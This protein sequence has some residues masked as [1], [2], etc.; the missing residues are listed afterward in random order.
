MLSDGLVRKSQVLEEFSGSVE[1]SLL[2]RVGLRSL[3]RQTVRRRR[4]FEHLLESSDGF[5]LQNKCLEILASAQL[6][7][8]FL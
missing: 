7:L 2:S 3:Q 4:L 8:F 1:P 6:F 5:R